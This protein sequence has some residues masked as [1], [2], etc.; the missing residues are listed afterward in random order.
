MFLLNVDK[1]ENQQYCS[2][3]DVIIIVDA[4]LLILLIQK[5]LFIC[6]PAYELLT[7]HFNA[8]SNHHVHFNAQSNHF[9]SLQKIIFQYCG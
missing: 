3:I 4:G 2:T 7:V 5:F 6:V 8:Q 1:R 9:F